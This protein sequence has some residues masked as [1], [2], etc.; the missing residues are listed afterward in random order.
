[1]LPS[2]NAWR[3]GFRN[4]ADQEGDAQANSVTKTPLAGPA[5]RGAL[6]G[7][8]AGLAISALLTVLYVESTDPGNYSGPVLPILVS[9]SLVGAVI[10]AA[11]GAR[12][13]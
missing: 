9:G 12:Q 1:M 13:E 5:G 2:L 10:G 3:V 6:I 8:A 11:I 7:G 4:Q